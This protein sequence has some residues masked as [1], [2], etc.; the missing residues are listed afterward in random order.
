MGFTIFDYPNLRD[1][2]RKS[3]NFDKNMIN[4]ICDDL[5][6]LNKHCHIEDDFFRVI[7]TYNKIPKAV[8]E[9]VEVFI[10]FNF[11]PLTYKIMAEVLEIDNNTV[12]QRIKRNEKKYFTITTKRPFKIALKKNIKE[13]YFL[14]DKNQ[15]QIC[16]KTFKPEVLNIR[17]KNPNL[18][19]KY[20]WN[21]VLTSC[22]S[23]KSKNLVK[24]GVKKTGAKKTQKYVPWEYK[25]IRIKKIAKNLLLQN[26]SFYDN[27]EINELAGWNRSNDSNNE[28]EPNTIYEFDELKGK[29]WFHLIG[30][31]KR[32]TSTNIIKILNYFGDDGWE[33]IS[34]SSEAENNKSLIPAYRLINSMNQEDIY[35]C[36]LKRKRKE[37]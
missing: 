36:I 8:K 11:K 27:P 9:I 7:M 25:E 6:T 24:K 20:N 4:F 16:R 15:C 33:L 10:R 14:R 29:G 17:F 18:K 34:I 31:N 30:D 37:S 23:C 26:G 1:T 35:Y 3:C 19:D 22:K 28:D 32:I 21:N 5:Y 12:I 13:I 2:S